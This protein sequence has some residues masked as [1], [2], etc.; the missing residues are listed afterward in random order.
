MLANKFEKYDYKLLQYNLSKEYSRLSNHNG[1]FLDRLNFDN[2]KRQTKQVR[3]EQMIKKNTYKIDIAEQ[4]KTFNRLIDDAN[5]RT[6]SKEKMK[7]LKEQIYEQQKK[8]LGKT[9]KK[10]EWLKIYNERYVNNFRLYF[11]FGKFQNEKIRK[12]EEMKKRID[13]EREEDELLHCGEKKKS[14]LNPERRHE[15]FIRNYE[16]VFRRQFKNKVKQI[17]K[18]VDDYKYKHTRDITMNEYLLEKNNTAENL[19]INQSHKAEIRHDHKNRNK[20]GNKRTVIFII[21]L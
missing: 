8:G 21:Y 5:R 10:K 18:Q 7:F 3:I 4:N 15:V 11:R 12:L 14:K 6:E 9:V 13:D 1:S 20:N 17:E 16:E 2:Y 19:L